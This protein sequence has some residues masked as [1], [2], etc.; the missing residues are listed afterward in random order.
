MF[1]SLKIDFHYQQSVQSLEMS[2]NGIS[3]GSTLFDI[4]F[5]QLNFHDIVLVFQ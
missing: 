3:S 4:F 2:K 5:F 1:L